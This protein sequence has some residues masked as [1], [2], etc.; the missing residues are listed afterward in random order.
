MI[1]PQL[2]NRII[3][4]SFEQS[5]QPHVRLG[6]A[7]YLA[8][9]ALGIF[10][11]IF[12]RGALVVPG[13]A[14][15][16]ANSISA[17]RF[18]WFAGITGDLLMQVLDVPLIVLFYLLLRAVNE[19]LALFATLINLVQTAV[20]VANKL[21][22]VVAAFLL[23]NAGYLGALPVE[24]RHALSYLAIRLHEYGLGVGFIFFGFAC[25]VHGYLI[26]RSRFFPATLGVLLFIAG[27]SYLTNSFALLL[28]PSL[29]SAMFPAV[30]LP[31]LVGELAL[32]VWLIV[33]G[34]NLERW[35]RRKLEAAP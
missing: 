35:K 31:A 24:Q 17:S 14:A 21:N 2:T 7:F 27:L 29:A 23:E 16:T 20:L 30:L 4:A 22:L 10:G 18:L 25:L 12:V 33:K 28:A 6:G 11:E 5:P 19:G 1:A 3:M 13:D 26:F 32:A 9:I 8:I 34:V 15:A